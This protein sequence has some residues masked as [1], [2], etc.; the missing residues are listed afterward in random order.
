[1]L[2]I[3]NLFYNYLLRLPFLLLLYT[4]ILIIT[5]DPSDFLPL[6][7]IFT[8]LCALDILMTR[9]RILIV[10]IGFVLTVVFMVFGMYVSAF[11][12]LIFSMYRPEQC[13][14]VSSIILLVVLFIL[15]AITSLFIDPGLGIICIR[16]LVTATVAKIS[17]KQVQNLDRFL[18]SYYCRGVSR[19]TVSSLIKK[20]YLITGT[21]LIC[22]IIVSFIIQPGGVIIPVPDLVI[23][24]VENAFDSVGDALVM[25]DEGET[26]ELDA[27]NPPDEPMPILLTPEEGNQPSVLY[28]LIIALAVIFIITVVLLLNKLYRPDS[29]FEDYD[30]VTEETDEYIEIMPEKRSRMFNFGTNHTIRRMFKRKVKEYVTLKSI[31]TQKSDTPKNL[32]GKINEWEDIGALNELYHKARYSGY[33]VQRAELSVLNNGRKDSKASQVRLGKLRMTRG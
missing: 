13:G 33:Q 26:G 17:A 7:I 11:A 25:G 12:V 18:N 2:K 31:Y 19:K 23:Q 21:C 4:V 14:T 32:A 9:Y 6:I 10:T 20:S 28:S 24:R 16:N 1:M 15:T 8:V 29:Q 3:Y 30:D 22:F 5:G 27:D